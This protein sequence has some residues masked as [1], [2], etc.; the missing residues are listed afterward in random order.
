MA[1]RFEVPDD[2][3]RAMSNL[4]KMKEPNWDVISKYL[5]MQYV[6]HANNA[7]LGIHLTNDQVRNYQGASV[8][9]FNLTTWI[10]NPEEELAVRERNKPKEDEPQIKVPS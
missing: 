3:L 6:Q 7:A 10:E 1:S 4:K 2:V 8:F 9:L 5:A